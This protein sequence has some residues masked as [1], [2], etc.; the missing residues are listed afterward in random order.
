MT[1]G[2]YQALTEL[3]RETLARA[4][5]MAR[6][7]AEARAT[8]AELIV[9]AEVLCSCARAERERAQELA[10]EWLRRCHT[11]DA[12]VHLGTGQPSQAL[13]RLSPSRAETRAAIRQS[14]TTS[15]SSAAVPT[16][17]IRLLRSVCRR[18]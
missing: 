6:R 13:N 16:P 3:V 9:I 18:V 2:E 17:A 14:S 7:S 11:D 8:A 4:R 15:P 5:D 12:V 10:S 1:P